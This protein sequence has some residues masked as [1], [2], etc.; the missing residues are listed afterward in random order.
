MFEISSWRVQQKNPLLAIVALFFFVASVVTL[1]PYTITRLVARA[2]GDATSTPTTDPATELASVAIALP[3]DVVSTTTPS[4][5]ISS[6][7]PNIA[8]TTPIV[9]TTS[10]TSTTET[11][12]TT[13]PVMPTVAP[14]TATTTP[15]IIPLVLVPEELPQ[16]PVVVLD[17]AIQP[18]IATIKILVDGGTSSGFPI[19]VTFIA[20]GGKK[21]EQTINSNN[22]GAFS[23]VLTS[24]RYYAEI[25]SE[26]PHYILNGDGPHFF[27]NASEVKDLGTYTLVYR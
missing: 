27:I 7:T 26:D 18:G 23:Q 13:T 21:T 12:A 5:E 20:V 2:E 9:A 11:V 25:T 1:S 10:A 3:S 17:P 19:D 14:I 6:S 16:P 8:T 24:G 4:F 22:A 15:E